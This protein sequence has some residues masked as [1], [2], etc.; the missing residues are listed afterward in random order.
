MLTNAKL[1]KEFNLFVTPPLTLS[2]SF[3]HSNHGFFE[4]GGYVKSTM[5]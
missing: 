5:Y 3:N 4:I 1:K 2:F